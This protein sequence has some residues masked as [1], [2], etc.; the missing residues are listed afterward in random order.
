MKAVASAGASS[1]RFVGLSVVDEGTEE[2]AR[3]F[4]LNFPLYR[5]LAQKSIDSY[6]LQGTPQTIVVKEG[7]VVDAVWG[8]AYVGETARAVER[9]FH[10]RLPGLI[11]SDVLPSVPPRDLPHGEA[12]NCIDRR[13]AFFGMGARHA[14]DGIDRECDLSGEWTVAPPPQF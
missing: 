11:P 12:G 6:S 4:D 8:G 10:V 7:G 9:Y 1:Y 2:F 3:A 5:D 13:G 14:I